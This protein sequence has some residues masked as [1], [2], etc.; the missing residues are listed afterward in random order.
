MNE[1]RPVSTP[2]SLLWYAS[3]K[4]LLYFKNFNHFYLHIR[5]FSGYSITCSDAYMFRF[6]Y[7]RKK[8][9]AISV[10]RATFLL[11]GNV[12]PN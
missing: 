6:S 5:V 7:E 11:F 1:G 4:I 2:Y 10:F 12:T 3:S 9:L 8:K